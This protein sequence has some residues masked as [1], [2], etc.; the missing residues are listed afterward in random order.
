MYVCILSQDGEILL[1]RHMQTSP[2]M[3]RKAMAP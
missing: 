1:H 2:E 3:F